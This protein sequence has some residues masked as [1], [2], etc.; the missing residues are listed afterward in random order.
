MNIY[1]DVINQ[2]PTKYGI[3]MFRYKMTNGV[4]TDCLLLNIIV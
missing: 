3:M 1:Y 4:G 2:N